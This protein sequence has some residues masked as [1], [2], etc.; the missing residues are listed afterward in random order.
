MTVNDG[1]KSQRQTCSC[2]I[3]WSIGFELPLGDGIDRSSM[4]LTRIVEFLFLEDLP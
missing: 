4:R 3:G 1:N 2:S